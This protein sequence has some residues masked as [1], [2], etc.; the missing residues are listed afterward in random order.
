MLHLFLAQATN[1]AG[2]ATTDSNAQQGGGGYTGLLIYPVLLALF[3]FLFFRPQSQAK[4]KQ[5]ELIKS[6]KTGDQVVTTGGIHGVIT[7]VKDKTVM[8]KVADNVKIEVE[9]AHLEKIM[10]DE[11]PAASPDG[12]VVVTKS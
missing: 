7:N 2:A 3:Y 6:A 1:A 5:E 4:K 10:R 11:A 9:K 8:V 12:K